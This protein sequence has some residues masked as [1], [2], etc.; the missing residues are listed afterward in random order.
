MQHIFIIINNLHKC[1]FQFIEQTTHRNTHNGCC[2]FLVVILFLCA[3]LRH[4]ITAQPLNCQKITNYVVVKTVLDI[5]F[6][7]DN[8]IICDIMT[9]RL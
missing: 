3:L 4:I 9:E 6:S 8:D 1:K 5:H 7:L 2:D